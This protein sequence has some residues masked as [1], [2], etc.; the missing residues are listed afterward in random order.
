[1]QHTQAANRATLFDPKQVNDNCGF[2]LIAQVDGKASHKLIKTAITGLDR[3]QHRGGVAA[4]GLTGDGCGLLLQKPDG[5]FRAIAKEN[6]WHL[7]NNYAVGMVFLSQD[8]EKAE[9]AKEVLTAELAKETLSVVGFRD[10]PVNS[11]CLGELALQSAP[12][13]VQVFVNAPEGW[14]SFDLERRLFMARKRLEKNAS[15][16]EDQD[17]YICS[18]SGLVV[19][20]KGLMLAKDLPNF[21]K[22]LADLRMQSAICLFHQRFSTN[23][24]PRWRLAQPFRYLAHN[25]EINTIRGNREWAKAR[26]YKFHS[27]LI[28]DLQDAAP[29]VD[30][31]G[32]DSS[33]L[34][35]MLE[36]LLAGGMDLFRA[37]RL[38]VPPAW[39]NDESLDEQTRAF[40]QF[41]AMHMEPWDGP[42]G[43]VMSNGRFAACHLD[44]NGLRPARYML[45]EDNVLT[46]A[47]EI[48]IWDYGPDEVKEKGRVGPGELFV[49]DT[50]EGKIWRQ[51]D[52]EASLKVRH[53]YETWLKDCV[54]H[55]PRQEVATRLSFTPRLLLKTQQFFGLTFE[56]KQQVLNVMAK[57]GVEATGS[58]GDDTPFAV[59]SSAPRSTFDFF[60]QRFAQVTN[61]PI[62]PLR[63][64][65][66]MSL[67]TSIGREHNVFLE[68]HGPE[69]RLS[70][71]SPVLL[72]N[73]FNA[74]LSHTD[75]AFKAVRLSLHYQSDV[76]LEAAIKALGEA[77][78]KAVKNGAVILVLSDRPENAAPSMSVPSALALG[79]VQSQLVAAN[80]RCDSNLIL[81]VGDV[82]DAHQ[83]AVCLG[84]GATAVYP[85]LAEATL[86][87]ENDTQGNT[88]RLTNY[89]NALEKGLLKIMSKMG[90]ST[91]SSYRCAKLFDILGL[92]K[93]ITD[94]CFNEQ[95]SQLGGLSFTQLE[96]RLISHRK[97]QMSLP[98][99]AMGGIYKYSFDGEYHA[100]NPDV[101]TLLQKAVNTGEQADYNAFTDAV[102]ARPPAV[103]RDLLTLAKPKKGIPL[104]KVT[105]AKS[106]YPLF[107][108]A[109]MSIGALSPEA[110]EALA[111]AMNALGGFSNSGEGGEARTRYKSPLNSK[112]KQ[113]ASGRFGVN[114]EYLM[115]AEVIQIK[116][117][118]GA[119]PGEGGQLPGDK[120]TPYIAKLRFSV[121]GVTLISPPPHHDIYSIEDLA[122]LI[123]DL[124]QLNPQ[125]KIS[126]K[127]VASQGVGTIAVGVAKANADYITI[128]GYDG[129]TGASPLTSVKHAGMPWE[130]GI[131]EAHQALVA[132]G[133]RHKVRLQ[134]DGGLKTGLDLIKAAIL[135]AESFAFGTAPMVALGCK[136]LRI[137]H[138]NNCATGVATQ[139]DVLRQKHFH[140]VAEKVIRYFEFL[141]HDVRSQLAEL[142]VPNLQALIGRTD[143]LKVSDTAQTLGL[144]LAPLLAQAQPLFD[145]PCYYSEPNPP[146]DQ[147]SLNQQIM[148][149][150]EP[151]IAKRQDLTLHYAV[152]NTD[153]SVGTTLSGELAKRFASRGFAPNTIH[154]S[155]T[156]SA[157]QSLGAFN[158]AGVALS[159]TGDANDYVGKGMSGG[160]IAITPAEGSAFN[161]ASTT[162]AGN[163]CLYGATGGALYLNGKA[164]ERFA[165]RNSGAT[166]VVEG[167]GDNGCEYMT[168]G[169]V[170]VLGAIGRNFAAGMTGGIVYV[171]D[172]E[173]QLAQGLN[174]EFVEPLVLAKHPACK[175][176]L[177]GIL[178]RHVSLTGSPQAEAILAEYETYAEEFVI[179]KP[180]ATP[181]H[182]LLGHRSRSSAEL[183]IEAQ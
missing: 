169:N 182:A 109:A 158:V 69:R 147:G 166:A 73:D 178:E 26:S 66:V 86:V 6:G 170:V 70:L 1:M 58:M 127:L 47:S 173:Q 40:Y 135:G 95:H 68:T 42:A 145:K 108:S 174:T 43:I 64:S 161:A 48:G 78:I 83:L 152:H 131:A 154:V 56:E 132:N 142:G 163:T 136:Y 18:L 162:I 102:A 103:F 129:G 128:A 126:V 101:V 5:F 55:I 23:T 118:Q 89:R 52:I 156:G 183:R 85:Y 76:S 91:I 38:L 124:K 133:L 157:G 94:V 71:P 54:T 160:H 12:D 165:V 74:I 110:H 98:S 96:A 113:V 39:Q 45:T 11:D 105:D 32:S 176:H 31:T 50:L 140:G 141:A 77:A 149:D 125:A 90:V 144:D 46:L 159:V 148:Q 177:R 24:L 22:D 75:D 51:E 88:T 10:V 34:D 100:Y 153:R 181:V 60:R 155:L 44:R 7:S 49:V 27:P 79:H 111:E 36:L 41:N 164:G 150:A 175:E 117:A 57:G 138:L 16:S 8:P 33:S 114:A 4:D 81:E 167:V 130:L 9:A 65:H 37:M 3:M 25:G 172:S 116:M 115:S 99:L 106:L 15:L 119:K 20:Y 120:V 67:T 63:E 121:P 35:N 122:Q 104:D 84:Y 53:P 17:F 143:L 80:C 30:D 93:D 28:P 168:G 2:G 13:V 137:C 123:F 59:L 14:Q 179:V 107:D 21:Y 180:K 62:D 151:A 134:V 139:D 82:R 72:A 97:A 171:R 61:P 92:G 112:I 19:V 29:F 146:F 87:E